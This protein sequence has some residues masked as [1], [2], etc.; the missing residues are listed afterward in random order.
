MGDNVPW[1]PKRVRWML[2]S[3]L[4]P[5]LSSYVTPRKSFNVSEPQS[6]QLYNTNSTLPFKL[7]VDEKIIRYNLCKSLDS[8]C[9]M[10]GIC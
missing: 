6:S 1:L 2:S 7:G 5:T 3:N 9:Y 4:G 10:E 8:V